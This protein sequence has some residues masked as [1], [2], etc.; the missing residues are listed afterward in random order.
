MM[1]LLDKKNRKATWRSVIL[2][3]AESAIVGGAVFFLA[4]KAQ[5]V[6]AWRVTLPIWLLLCAAVGALWEWQGTDITNRDEQK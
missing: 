2:R 1:G 3:A 4:F 6:E 5:Y